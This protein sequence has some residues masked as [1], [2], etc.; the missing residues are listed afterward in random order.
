MQ[1]KQVLE[2]VASIQDDCEISKDFL[3]ELIE[4]IPEELLDLPHTSYENIAEDMHEELLR[5]ASEQLDCFPKLIVPTK[6]DGYVILPIMH[7]L[8]EKF[9]SLDKHS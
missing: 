8:I 5:Y 9:D 2:D 3:E 1:K 7:Y 6:E 4:E